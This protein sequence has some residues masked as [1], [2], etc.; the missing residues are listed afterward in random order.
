MDKDRDRRLAEVAQIAVRIEAE[1]GC[2]ARLLVAQW[3]HGVGRGASKPTGA[4]NYFGIKKA[5]APREVLH[6]HVPTRSSVGKRVGQELQFADY[7]SA[8]CVVP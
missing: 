3:A 6:R 1:T 7:D 4:A 8:G 2:P 5:S